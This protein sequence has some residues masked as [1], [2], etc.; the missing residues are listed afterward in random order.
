MMCWRTIYAASSNEL[1]TLPNTLVGVLRWCEIIIW[2]SR[3]S[4]AKRQRAHPFQATVSVVKGEIT[5]L[6]CPPFFSQMAIQA[7]V[8]ANMPGPRASEPGHSIRYVTCVVF[9]R[10]HLALSQNMTS[11]IDLAFLLLLITVCLG[12]CLIWAFWE[13]E[14]FRQRKQRHRELSSEARRSVRIDH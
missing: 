11:P 7:A 9:W 6:V 13:I 10:T 4:L 14:E 3:P 8:A 5:G 12:A 1:T 2:S